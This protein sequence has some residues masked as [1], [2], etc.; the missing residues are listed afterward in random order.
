ML[1]IASEKLINMAEWAVKNEWLWLFFCKLLKNCGFSSLV[2]LK[3]GISTLKLTKKDI[4]SLFK[5]DIK[6][7]FTDILKKSETFWGTW[8]R[9][10]TIIRRAKWP[11]NERTFSLPDYHQSL[12]WKQFVVSISF[13]FNNL[14]LPMKFKIAENSG[15][16]N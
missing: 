10:I 1:S 9:S 8:P 6:S 16:I 13:W 14:K 2:T 5:K 11:D 4:K 3:I 12:N 7:L 15:G